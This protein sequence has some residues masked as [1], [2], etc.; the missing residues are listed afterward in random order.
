MG[1]STT[2]SFVTE[3]ALRTTRADER[4]LLI[5]LDCGRQVY[6]VCLGEARKRAALL[7]QSKLYQAARKLPKGPKGSPRAKTRTAAFREAR[8]AVGFSEYDL[9]RYAKRF[10]HSWL[11]EHLDANTVQ[12]IASRVFFIRALS[13]SPAGLSP[14]SDHQASTLQGAADAPASRSGAMHT[15]IFLFGTLVKPHSGSTMSP[16]RSK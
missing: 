16:P 4:A 5:R 7:R 2:P 13:F 6:N 11:G 12:T 15:I 10:G 9:H 8:A 14:S 3:L 1:R